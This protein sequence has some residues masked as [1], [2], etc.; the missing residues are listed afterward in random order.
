MESQTKT[1]KCRQKVQNATATVATAAVA[2]DHFLG[3]SLRTRASCCACCGSGFVNPCCCNAVLILTHSQIDQLETPQKA[4][5]HT[6]SPC[7][8]IF[9]QVNCSRMMTLLHTAVEPLNPTTTF[10]HLFSNIPY[11]PMPPLFSP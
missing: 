5:K 4:G 10:S 11:A 2:S 6:N 9:L 3:L 1:R 7:H 8:G